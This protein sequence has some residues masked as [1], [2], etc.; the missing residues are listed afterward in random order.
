MSRPRLNWLFVSMFVLGCDKPPG[1]AASGTSGDDGGSSSDEGSKEDDE[2]DDDDTPAGSEEA[3]DSTTGGEDTTTSTTSS[4]GTTSTSTSTTTDAGTSTT[5]V[6]TTSTGGGTDTSGTDST[7]TEDPE[8]LDMTAEDFEC[9]AD[10][11]QVLGFR[12]NNLLGHLDEA[13]EVAE[14][15]SG[16]TYPVGTVIQH[17]PTEA[18]VKRAPGFSPETKDWEFFVLNIDSG[19]TQIVD[20][21]TTQIQTM[22]QTCASCHSQAPDPWDFVCN[23]WGAQGAGNCGFDFMDS[24]L[25]P[26]IDS[27]PRCP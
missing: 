26:Q 22:N 19:T 27:D 16:G 13:L 8:D 24:F 10:W 3:G 17:L 23:T 9:I 5:G 15:P 20:R 2:Q 1:D 14:S 21:G 18:M 7:G 12:I 11:P 6:D 4:T 25:Q